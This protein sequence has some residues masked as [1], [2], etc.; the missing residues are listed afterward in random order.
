M[1]RSRRCAGSLG[2]NGQRRTSRRRDGP[3]SEAIDHEPLCSG[4]APGGSLLA[5]VA[6]CGLL[7]GPRGATTRECATSPRPSPRLNTWSAAGMGQACPRTLQAKQFRGWTE[8]HTWAW[9]FT[10]GKPTGSRCHD[11]GGKDLIAAGKLTYDAGQQALSSRG[12]RA[13]AGRRPRYV[14]E[15]SLDESGKHPGARSRRSTAGKP[16]KLCRDTA[17]VGLAQRQLYPLHDGPGPQGAGRGSVHPLIEVG[18][19]K[20]GES[21]AAGSASHRNGPSAS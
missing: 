21:L 9:M 15:G 2:G 8:T 11:R 1:A 20:D 19:T 4:H 12:D 10:K 6:S 14:F 5:I 7:R 3:L 16:A 18:L 13:E 17:A